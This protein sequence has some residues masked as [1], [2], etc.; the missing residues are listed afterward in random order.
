MSLDQ[1]CTKMTIFIP[2]GS[3]TKFP[4]NAFSFCIPLLQMFIY[5]K[6]PNPRS[7]IFFRPFVPYAQVSRDLVFQIIS[8]LLR[9]APVESNLGLSAIF[10]KSPSLFIP[11][12]PSPCFI[13]KTQYLMSS[14]YNKLPIIEKREWSALH[15]VIFKHVLPCSLWNR[16]VCM[17]SL[18][19]LIP[20]S[21]ISSLGT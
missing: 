5:G 20:S 14:C 21:H 15:C 16:L 12:P 13:L 7:F 9:W 10:S 8:F 2:T 17:D 1:L 3:A 18:E 6:P 4:Y 19:G 11:N